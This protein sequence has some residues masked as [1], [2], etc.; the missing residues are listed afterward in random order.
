MNYSNKLGT[1][2]YPDCQLYIV[3][4]HG[5]SLRGTINRLPAGA[6]RANTSQN[7][8]HCHVG[9]PDNMGAQTFSKWRPLPRG[10]S[11][12]HHSSDFSENGGHCHMGTSNK[13]RAQTFS[14][15]R[16]L[17]RGN[18]RQHH[19]SDFSE[20]GCHCQVGA[21]NI[22]RT[23]TLQ[24]NLIFHTSNICFGKH[25]NLK[26]KVHTII[27]NYGAHDFLSL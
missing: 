5:P 12:Q 18:S 3:P 21:P 7:G 19:S 23:Q 1:Y 16:P 14:K 9:T 22:F 4:P 11:R 20:N 26:V 17:P 8:G 27:E 24:K 25:I 10:N 2:E 13:M 6:G 15:L